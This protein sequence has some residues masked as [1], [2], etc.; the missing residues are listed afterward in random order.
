MTTLPKIYKTEAIVLKHFAFGEADYLLT[1][2]TPNAGR[3]KAVVKGAR[4]VKSKLGGH[5]EPLMH[6]S[7]LIT[8]GQN[9]DT[10]NQAEVL[11]GHRVVREDLDRLSQAMYMT[12]LVDA[13]TPEEQSN[14]S[15]YRLL[16]EAMRSL[17]E[18]PFPLLLPY[19]QLRLL[20]HSGFMPELYRCV[21]CGK[22]L[23]PGHHRFIPDRGG[24]LCDS[25]HVLNV[26]VLPLS[27]DT[28]KV[29]RFLQ[30]EEYNGRVE[31]LHLGQG[32]LTE[33]Q[34]L[35]E[36]M[37]RHV[38]DIEVKASRFLSQVAH[39]RTSDEATT[40]TASSAKGQKDD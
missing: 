19:F 21:E 39:G 31:R 14:Y 37:L 26:S 35:L 38:L 11:D 16:V 2:Y 36:A 7:L 12:E 17:T 9:L 40:L 13:I 30:K 10:I 3:L 25:C 34:R 4:R 5:L 27:L 15:I 24:S 33:L 8:R 18:D 28:L 22:T 1:L 23:A 29:L 6:T 32:T 20:G